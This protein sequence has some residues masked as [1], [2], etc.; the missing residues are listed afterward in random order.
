MHDVTI[1]C[2]QMFMCHMSIRTSSLKCGRVPWKF[3]RLFIVECQERIPFVIL[4]YKTNYYI[5]YHIQ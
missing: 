5:I 3:D 1:V 2:M 4:F